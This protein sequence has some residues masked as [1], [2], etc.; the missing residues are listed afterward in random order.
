MGTKPVCV[1]CRR[2]YRP[3]RNGTYFIEAKP[4]PGMI[5]PP[6]LEA[7]HHWQ[8]YKIWMGDLWKCQGCGH[9]IIAGTGQHPVAEDYKEYFDE[10]I[11]RTDADSIIVNDC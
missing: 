5:A 10:M 6:G 11:E 7:P 9:E 2:F 4:R 8:P 3:E 1:A